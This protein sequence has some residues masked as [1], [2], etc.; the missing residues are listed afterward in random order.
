ML[1]DFEAWNH[2]TLAQLAKDLMTENKMLREQIEALKS[3]Q[4]ALIDKCHK[5]GKEKSDE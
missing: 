4:R 3:D 1:T 2:K 5:I